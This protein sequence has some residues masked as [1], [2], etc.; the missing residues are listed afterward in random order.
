MALQGWRQALESHVRA[1]IFLENVV[2]LKFSNVGFS[3]IQQ[4]P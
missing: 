1:A 2:C 3:L 4:A